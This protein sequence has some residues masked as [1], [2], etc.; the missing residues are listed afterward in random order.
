MKRAAWWLVIASVWMTACSSSGSEETSVGGPVASDSRSASEDPPG[1][2]GDLDAAWSRPGPDD[3]LRVAMRL[4][5]PNEAANPIQAGEQVVVVG[6]SE[7]V[8]YDI[9]TGDTAWDTRLPGDVC[10][11]S[12]S[13]DDSEVMVLLLGSEG[14]CV[15]ALA[16]DTTNG[17]IFWRV[18]IP[19]ASRAFGH[20][21]SVG[22]DTAVVTGECAGFTRLRLADGSV[23][24]SVLGS[25]L[26]RRCATATS[27]GTTIVQSSGGRL[28]V[29]DASSGKRSGSWA[30]RGLGRVGDILTRDPLVIT[31]RYASGARLVDLSGS[32]P[33]VFGR[34]DGWFGGEVPASYRLGNTLWVGY[35][36]STSSTGTT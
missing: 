32:R 34:D 14:H 26:A 4:I 16:L 3:P 13:V 9:R 24:G 25:N 18:P 31:A 36:G 20:E 8:A 17:D 35:N 29:F 15:I 19:R 6:Y 23:A 28:S 2:S 11:G 30:A 1:D 27:D 22:P 7:V 12:K 33:R 5:A 10:A 21:V